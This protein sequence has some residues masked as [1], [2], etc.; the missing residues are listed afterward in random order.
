[1]YT[2]WR[3]FNVVWRG[4][5]PLVKKDTD[6]WGFGVDKQVSFAHPAWPSMVCILSWPEQICNQKPEGGFSPICGGL[7]C[8]VLSN[9][10][11]TQLITILISKY[12]D[13]NTNTANDI[14]LLSAHKSRKYNYDEVHAI[15]NA[16]LQFLIKPSYFLGVIWMPVL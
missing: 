1:M 9:L 4:K 10:S 2:S 8:Q 11:R 6:L 14:L 3:E 15:L 7:I 16:I 5:I 12:T 13:K